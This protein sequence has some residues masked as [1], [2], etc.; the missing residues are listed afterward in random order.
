MLLFLQ[1]AIAQRKI[2]KVPNQ[3]PLQIVTVK[4]SGGSFDLGT[5]EDGT[6]RKPAHTVTLS[7]YSIGAYFPVVLI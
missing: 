7:D 2:N 6:D 1:P 4:V 3:D 5:D